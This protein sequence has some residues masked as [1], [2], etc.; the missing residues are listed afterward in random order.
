MAW[1]IAVP[2]LGALVPWLVLGA[3]DADPGGLL[4][5]LVAVAP[6]V[7]GLGAVSFSFAARVRM[8]PLVPFIAA[9]AVFLFVLLVASD[10]TSGNKLDFGPAQAIAVALPVLALAG[11]VVSLLWPPEPEPAWEAEQETDELQPES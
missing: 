3:A 9:A 11:G 6:L 8:A 4:L 1:L 2:V 7:G 5:L 10:M